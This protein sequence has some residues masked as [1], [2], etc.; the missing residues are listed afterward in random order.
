[1]AIGLIIDLVK[2]TDK[3]SE[4]QKRLNE[5]DQQYTGSLREQTGQ[6]EMLMVQI[7]KTNPGTEERIKLV[8]RLNELIPDVVDKQTL[9][10][11]SLQDLKKYEADYRTELEKRI[12][13]QAN[14]AKYTE[15]VRQQMEA[16]EELLKARQA[17]A[18][19]E[20]E[21]NKANTIGSGEYF[22]TATRTVEKAR[23]RV[24]ELERDL[25]NIQA[26]KDKN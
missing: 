26:L 17:L 10:G 6:M 5:I 21:L 15:L 11:A 24:E 12:R 18:R 14:E 3:L 8:D 2:N 22:I 9:Y 16:E 20:S 7:R 25:Q 4:S 23:E 13:M 19:S 1:M